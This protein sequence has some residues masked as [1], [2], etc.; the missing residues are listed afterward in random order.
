V[1]E[2]VKY[3]DADG[4]YVPRKQVKETNEEILEI[5]KGKLA[6]QN[7]KSFLN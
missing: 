2:A 4:N 6:A 7:C 3:A 1:R 5:Y